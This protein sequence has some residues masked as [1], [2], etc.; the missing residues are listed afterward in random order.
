MPSSS[1]CCEPARLHLVLERLQLRQLRFDR[2]DD[3]QPAQPLAPR[4]RRSRPWRRPAQRSR[5]LPCLRQSSRSVVDRLLQRLRQLGRELDDLGRPAWR[6]ACRRPR[7]AACRPHR[8]TA[9][10]PWSPARSVTPV[11]SSPAF[12]A[13][14]RIRRAPV[15]VLGQALPQ[16]AV[17]A[18]RVHR[19]G[20]DGVDRVAAD[21]LLDV[22]HVAI[23]LVLDPGAGP[24]Q[25][26]RQRAGR[27]QLLPAR[28][29]RPGRDSAGRPAW[30]WRSPPCRAGAARPV[31]PAFTRSSIFLSI[32]ASMRLTKKL[33]TLA[34]PAT[35]SPLGAPRPPARR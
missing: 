32:T 4:P 6:P 15:D 5:S 11:R 22:Q 26:L 30:R 23:G 19:R 31:S 2:V 21:Q 9:R 27:G 28:R 8:R 20:R 33:A 3:P 10:P 29:S 17:V 34:I 12:S 7:R 1:T 16:L 14:A 25:A 13:S 24:Q 18:E 35:L